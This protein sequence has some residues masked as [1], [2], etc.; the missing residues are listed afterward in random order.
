MW[1][2]MKVSCERKKPLVGIPN[3]DQSN[4][5]KQK[6][7]VTTC[8]SN[9]GEPRDRRT[10]AAEGYREPSRAGTHETTTP[11]EKRTR[12]EGDNTTDRQTKGRR[13][14]QAR[15]GGQTDEQTDGR[16]DGRRDGR[17]ERQADTQADRQTDTQTR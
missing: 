6:L 15:A 4:I 16:T 7:E 3:C 5:Y 8:M 9:I 13:G 10:T 17:T 12:G 2:L 11:Q 1:D 14:K